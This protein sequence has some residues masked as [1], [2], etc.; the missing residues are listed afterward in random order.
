MHAF[1]NWI[2]WDFALSSGQNNRMLG[3]PVGVGEKFS[4]P[5]NFKLARNDFRNFP[6]C[7]ADGGSIYDYSG[8]SK[9]KL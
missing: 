9:I 6:E 5:C 1:D 3:G 7:A 8:S 2:E 4:E